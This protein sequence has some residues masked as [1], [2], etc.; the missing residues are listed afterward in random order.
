MDPFGM[1]QGDND[2]DVLQLL[3]GEC[4]EEVCKRVTNATRDE[5]LG[6]SNGI[7]SSILP[8]SSTQSSQ[9][10]MVSATSQSSLQAQLLGPMSKDMDDF[11]EDNID[12]LIKQPT[13]DEYFCSVCHKSAH[14]HVCNISFSSEIQHEEHNRGRKHK[15]MVQQR[16]EQGVKEV[17]PVAKP[18]VCTVC[19]RNFFCEICQKPFCSQMQ[20]EDHLRGRKHKK[21]AM[22]LGKYPTSQENSNANIPSPVAQTADASIGS[23]PSHSVL[24]TSNHGHNGNN[25]QQPQQLQQHIQHQQQQQQQQQHH[26]QQQHSR[27]SLSPSAGMVDPSLYCQVCDAQLTSAKQKE[28]HDKGRRHIYLYNQAM[29]NGNGM[30]NGQK[31]SSSGGI[32]INQYQQNGAGM[33]G[34]RRSGQVNQQQQ[35]SHS[36]HHRKQTQEFQMGSP[37]SQM[38]GYFYQYADATTGAGME[39]QIY[40]TVY[41]G[42]EAF[43][44]PEMYAGPL[45]PPMAAFSPQYN[46]FVFYPPPPPTYPT[47]YSTDPNFQPVAPHPQPSPPS[48]TSF[49][50]KHFSKIN[51]A[52]T[53]EFKPRQQPVKQQSE[54]SPE[55]A[56]A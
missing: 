36:Q 7:S 2:M 34:I 14:C 15:Q 11:G 48:G 37:P 27:E 28:E 55:K 42:Q 43:G 22:K 1:E 54:S 40:P 39:P 13:K 31:H 10:P 56:S 49:L 9:Q 35:G 16:A 20:M 41:P 19:R 51:V 53:P 52:D 6:D 4:I 32:P 17:F 5:L 8:M 23:A 26:H 30:A 25:M 44:S 3:L 21:L 33:N 46:A 12:L 50:A 45:S 29:S 47:I 24:S 38:N 18:F